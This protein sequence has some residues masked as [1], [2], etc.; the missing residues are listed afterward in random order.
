MLSDGWTVSLGILLVLQGMMHGEKI[1]ET[2]SCRPQPSCHEC[3]QSHPSC[4]WCKQPDFVQAG[5]PDAERCAPRPE[6]EHR[7]CLASE[8]MDPQGKHHILE[9][10]PLRD[11]IYHENIT[12]LS[13]Q[14]IVLQLRPGK[15]QSFTVRF[16]RAE[17][18]PVDLYYL[19]DLSYSMKDDL[20]KIKQLGSDLMAALR[21]VTTSVKIGFGAFV[22]KTVLPYVNMVPSK[23][24][25]PCL[26]AQENCQ[27]AFSYKHVLALTE[28]ASEFESRVG[29]QRISANLDD[30]EGGFDAIMQAAICKDQIGWRNVTS[31]LVFTSDGAFHTAG[32]GKLGG[33][34]MPNDGRC[35]LD[36]NGVYSKSHLYDYPSLGHLAEVLSKS[37]IQPIFAV[38]SSKLSLYKE[39]SKHIPKSVVGELKSDSRNVVQLIED[40]YKSLASTV[41]LGHFSDL[42]PGISIAYDSHCGDTATYGQT[43]GGECSDVSVNQLVQFTVKIRTTTCLP[44]SQKLVL[45][46]LGVGEEVQVELSTACECQCGDTQPDAHHCSG[47]H[48]NLTCG[49]CRCHEGYV[50]RRCDCRKEEILGSEGVSLASGPFCNCDNVACE[51]HNGQL[52][53]GNGQCRCGQ[54]QCQANYTGSACE[55]SLDTNGC[56]QEGKICNG[57]GHCACNRCQCDV[58][59]LGSHCA[60]HQMPCEVHRDCAECKAFGTGPLSQ[61]CSNSCS[62]MVRMLVAPVDERWCQMKG[63]DGRL[64]IY[65]IEK[66]KT[67]SILLTVNDRK[68][69]DSTRQPNLMPVLMSGLIVVS[70]GVLL[71]TLSRA[72]VEI[73]DRRKFR[74]LEKERKSALWSQTNNFK[75]KSATTRVTTKGEHL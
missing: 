62:Q 20:L 33:I 4:A 3:I 56:D 9:D 35:H 29:Q 70:I 59:W 75:F 7:G 48:G 39:L 52:C 36:A 43:E 40:A 2:G 51:R 25:N 50:G 74:R 32:D 53:A 1:A 72:I 55:C 13:P 69:P 38:T 10:R 64:L 44:E 11:N 71:I 65:L 14:R 26:N 22:D 49:I 30:A 34:L 66:D 41:K 15:E 23:R 28:N 31:L 61:N 63:G 47:G 27:S 45:R 37:N 18:Y 5:E 8:I 73:C 42:P 46:V 67:G 54:C 12:Q 60:D 24:K 17:G 68:G 6:L 57:H 21:K 16:K 58:G 19:M